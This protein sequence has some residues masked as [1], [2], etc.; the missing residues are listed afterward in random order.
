MQ[1]HLKWESWVFWSWSLMKTCRGRDCAATGKACV[2]M[3]LRFKVTLNNLILRRLTSWKL[4][5]KYPIVGFYYTGR[6]LMKLIVCD[7]YK[8]SVY[9][10][11]QPTFDNHFLI[12]WTN[13]IHLGLVNYFLLSTSVL[14]ILRYMYYYALYEQVCVIYYTGYKY[15][16]YLF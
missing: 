6:H 16:T 13:F 8:Y 10:L 9:L 14:H 3:V 7:M 2:Q 5:S 4:F 1:S 11:C 12:M 15:Y